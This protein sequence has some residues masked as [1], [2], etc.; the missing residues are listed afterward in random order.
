MG[1]VMREE[2]HF[3]DDLAA[4][5]WQ[6]VFVAG[7]AGS[8][9]FYRLGFIKLPKPLQRRVLMHAV[10]MLRPDLRDVGYDAITRA[11][12]FASQPSES[13]Q[14]DLVARLNLVALGDLLILKD[15]D[16]QL[17]D[18]GKPLLP[19]QDFVGHLAPGNPLELRHGWWVTA[20]WID[21]LP[22]EW[23]AKVR[24]LG[25]HEVWLDAQRLALPLTV[26]GRREGERWQP[27]GMDGHHQSFQD[28]FITQKVAEHLRDLWPL[29]C[30]GEEV[31]WVAGMR[32]SEVFKVT[33]ETGKI[34][35]LQLIRREN[36]D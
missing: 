14:I 33:G 28:F 36:V 24:S 16:V 4:D 18:W 17:P 10:G 3:L 23:A 25:P 15:W 29:V 22:K 19:A 31:A 8:I 20:N 9:H 13:D 34:L 35:Q 27:L 2:D 26:R 11:L 12:A 21:E 5:A 6:G 1:M 7:N 32:P 30:S